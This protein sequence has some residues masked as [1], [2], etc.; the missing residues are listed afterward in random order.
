VSTI[1]EQGPFGPRKSIM[2]TRRAESPNGVTL[3]IV[4]APW[5][6]PAPVQAKKEAAEVLEA[7]LEL[8]V[9]TRAEL[10]RLIVD[11]F[12]DTFVGTPYSKGGKA[13]E[14]LVGFHAPK[15]RRR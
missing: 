15:L 14:P 8:P 11:E 1:I 4:Y 7:L 9:E 3:D 2:V 10:K 13:P 6:R 5:K 12:H